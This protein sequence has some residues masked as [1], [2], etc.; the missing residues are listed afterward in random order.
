MHLRVRYVLFVALSFIFLFS[1]SIL[2][3]MFIVKCTYISYDSVGSFGFCEHC[4]VWNI[5]ILVLC[6]FSYNIL[7]RDMGTVSSIPYS[8]C[9]LQ[10]NFSP[11]FLVFPLEVGTFIQSHIIIAHLLL[12]RLST[13]FYCCSYFTGSLVLPVVN[14]P[15]EGLMVTYMA[16]FFTAIV[17]MYVRCFK[18]FCS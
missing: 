11:F 6:D 13:L 12:F 14:G 15:T 18:Q 10:F 7:Y 1:F 5:Y 4:Y 17:G 16:H 8:L 3:S 9:N 2:V